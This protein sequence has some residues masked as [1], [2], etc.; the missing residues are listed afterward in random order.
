MIVELERLDD[1]YHMQVTNEGGNTVLLDGSPDIGGG[2]KAMRPMQMLLS[3]LAGCTAIDVILFLRK[4][5]EP[6]EDI[7]MTVTGE[8]EKDKTPSLFTEITIKY[9]LFGNIDPKK[10]E[11]AIS[12]S[13]DKYCSVSKMIE[14]Q[15][16]VK[17]EM[18]IFSNTDS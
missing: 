2:N 12:M 16:P 11:R 15:A 5:K 14:K 6:L 7:K 1:N 3:S 18:E 10:A 13:V 8:R 17:W 9:K 4:M